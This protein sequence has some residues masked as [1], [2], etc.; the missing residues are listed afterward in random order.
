V[1]VAVVGVGGVG[2]IVG[3]RLVAMKVRVRLGP[4]FVAGSSVRVRV[5]RVVHVDVRV[6]DGRVG[7]KMSV[8]LAQQRG[9]ARDHERAGAE[10]REGHGL[11]K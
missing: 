6:L 5:V 3:D 2:V 10:L 7:V 1:A 4:R 11:A 8:P 9:H